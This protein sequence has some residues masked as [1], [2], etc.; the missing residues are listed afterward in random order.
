MLPG[1]SS[2][3]Y[4]CDRVNVIIIL[5]DENLARK[6]FTCWFIWYFVLNLTLT[7]NTDC[8]IADKSNQLRKVIIL[9]G[10]AIIQDNSC[11]FPKLYHHFEREKR[12][13]YPP[14]H[15]FP[16]VAFGN[17][18]VRRGVRRRSVLYQNQPYLKYDR[19][20]KWI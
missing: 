17:R 2:V 12:I 15:S 5:V 14:T 3:I 4:I 11:R 20:E 19:V 10:I 6:N 8:D 1:M 13:A 18:C 7:R 9:T 16:S